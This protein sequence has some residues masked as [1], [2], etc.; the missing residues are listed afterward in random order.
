MILSSD[1]FQKYFNICT[2]RDKKFRKAFDVMGRSC[3]IKP[4]VG[5]NRANTGNNSDNG[6]HHHD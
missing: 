5:L 2:K 6:H 3:F 4:P 1:K